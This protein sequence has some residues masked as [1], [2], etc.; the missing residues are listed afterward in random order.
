MKIINVCF[1]INNVQYNNKLIIIIR[2]RGGGYIVLTTN[3]CM[4]DVDKVINM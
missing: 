1:G 2:R 3:V 4:Y